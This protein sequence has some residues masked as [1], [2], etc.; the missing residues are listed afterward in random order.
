M[1]KTGKLLSSIFVFSITFSLITILTNIF[2]PILCEPTSSDN[3][4]IN[5]NTQNSDIPNNDQSNGNNQTSNKDSATSTP[6]TY[7]NKFIQNNSQANVNIQT[8]NSYS[9]IINGKDVNPFSGL[10][11]FIEDNDII[12]DNMSIKVNYRTNQHID[13]LTHDLLF[14]NL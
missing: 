3:H 13:Y 8:F 6:R 4:Q 2:N 11:N 12:S 1:S 14:N 9:L 10:N 5:R 7:E